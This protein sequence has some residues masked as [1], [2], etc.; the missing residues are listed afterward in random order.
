M[1]QTARVRRL[2]PGNRAEI[3]VKR[4]SA[5][6]HDCSQCGGGCSEM[7][8]QS[9]VTAV[10]D[11][12]LGARPGDTV[13]VESRSGQVLWIAAVVYLL[14]LLLFFVFCFAGAALTQRE[15]TGLALGGV[16]FLIGIAVAVWANRVVKKRN[17]TAFSI[18]A[19]EER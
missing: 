17:M 13:R 11:N 16:G 12:P 8:V 6:G 9:E 18:T 14:P 3:A 10:A 19:V 2:L 4:Q 15:S 1:E 7:L 5:C